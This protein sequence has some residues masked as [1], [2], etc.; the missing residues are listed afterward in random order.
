MP[1]PFRILVSHSTRDT[2]VRVFWRFVDELQT[3]IDKAV[4]PIVLVNIVS[5]C[6]SVQVP[7]LPQANGDATAATDATMMVLT[8]GYIDSHWCDGEM[9]SRAQSACSTC[10]SHRLFPLAWRTYP[11]SN[12][13]GRD[14]AGWGVDLQPLITDEVLAQIEAQLWTPEDRPEAWRSA[15]ATTVGALHKF[16]FEINT[17]CVRAAC[18][19]RIA[20]AVVIPSRL[21]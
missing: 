3:A 8:Q 11:F 4:I 17:T 18:P 2:N 13:W 5:E 16:L 6:G 14:I 19:A 1:L 10:P 21:D 12:L 7:D 9:H 20:G 15:I